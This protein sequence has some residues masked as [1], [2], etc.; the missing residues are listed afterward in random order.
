MKWKKVLVSAFLL[1]LATSY[2]LIFFFVPKQYQATAELVPSMEENSLVGL[3]SL[4]KNFSSVLPAGLSSMKQESEMDLYNTIIYSRTSIELLIQ[5]F[6]LQRVY[7][8]KSKEKAVKLV[9]KSIKTTITLQNAFDLTVQSKT[10]QMA[11]D[12]ANYLVEYLNEKIIQMNVAKSKDNRIFLEQRYAEI[13]TSLKNAEDSL[14]AFQERTGVFEA[15]KQTMSTIETLAKLESDVSVKQVESSVADKIYG[16][17]SPMASNAKLSLK[18]FQNEVQRLKSNSNRSEIVIGLN[19]LPRK[20]L[21]YFRYYRDVKIFDE[22]LQ[23]IIPLYEQSKFEEQKKMP[24]LQV[25]DYAIPPERKA[26][27]P[28]VLMSGIIACMVLFFSV[29][30]VVAREVLSR[31]DNPKIAQIRTGLFKLK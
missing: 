15:G 2:L 14:K 19:S 18:E 31:N 13:K 11:C 26:Y 25:I 7:K 16:D 22:M 4:I 10:P 17:N 29:C 5:K 6:D 21:D 1:S 23:F 3:S 28:R 8:I 12:M 20:A 30:F 24:I 9:R 27:P